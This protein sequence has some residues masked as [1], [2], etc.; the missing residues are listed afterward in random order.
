[1]SDCGVCI[2]ISYGD[3]DGEPEI[4]ETR[5]PKSRKDRHCGEC[6]RII[7]RGETY[8]RCSGKFDGR[9]YDEVTCIGCAEVRDAFTCDVPPP[10]GQLWSEIKEFI[11]PHLNT[12][13]FDKL[14]TPQGKQFFRTQ[15]MKWKGFAA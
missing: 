8:Q 5:W 4:C 10:F 15:W 11:F 7:Q 14:D 12:S 1:M 3:C 13:C 6:N 2:G 9:F